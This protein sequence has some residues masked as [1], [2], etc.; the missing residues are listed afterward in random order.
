M[1]PLNIKKMKSV[2]IPSAKRGVFLKRTARG[3]IAEEKQYSNIEISRYRRI[4]KE[5]DALFK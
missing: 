1:K 5:L 2:K 4:E 3:S